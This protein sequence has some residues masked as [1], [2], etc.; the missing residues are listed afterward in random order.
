MGVTLGLEWEHFFFLTASVTSLVDC[1]TAQ[2]P[3]AAS[4]LAA[5]RALV[6]YIQCKNTALVA[7]AGTLYR[8]SS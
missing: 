6:L 8:E 5:A 1:Q 7:V 2:A 4:S 3:N